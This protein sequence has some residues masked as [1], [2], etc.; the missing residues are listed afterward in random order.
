[1]GWGGWVGGGHRRDPLGLEVERTFGID[2]RKALDP[3]L[4]SLEIPGKSL[5]FLEKEDLWKGPFKKAP[6]RRELLGP[7]DTLSCE[8]PL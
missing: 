4:G 2:E 7:L 6:A 5:G 8:G 1:M 3:G